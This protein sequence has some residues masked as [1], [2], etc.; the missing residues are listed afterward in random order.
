MGYMG[1]DPQGLSALRSR[2]NSALGDLRSLYDLCADPA[3]AEAK[4]SIA[5]A[6]QNLA[7]LWLPIVD[8]VL[9]C[10]PLSK[11]QPVAT[12][13]APGWKRSTD[14]LEPTSSPSTALSS[15][16]LASFYRTKSWGR[17]DY[18]SSRCPNNSPDPR[19][20]PC[21][22]P[23][24]QQIIQPGDWSFKNVLQYDTNLVLQTAKRCRLSD[25]C[26]FFSFTLVGTAGSARPQSGDTR[27]AAGTDVVSGALGFVPI[28]G[29]VLDSA[30]IVQ[31]LNGLVAGGSVAQPP[32][33]FD[34]DVQI[35]VRTYGLNGE[36]LSSK[37]VDTTATYYNLI[38][39]QQA[40]IETAMDHHDLPW[41][42]Y[43]PP[44][45]LTNVYPNL[46]DQNYGF[47]AQVTPAAG[48]GS[49][50]RNET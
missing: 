14:P 12:G 46:D 18:P 48:I 38:S 4:S 16:D 37:I 33:T 24:V 17:G 40:T 45:G 44:I 50:E 28:A 29:Q 5:G 20:D 36:V 34:V 2:L 13:S 30:Q 21:E 22:T 11:Y 35:V 1:Y 10:D 7:N 26:A 31:G 25:G 42:W 32:T 3:A 47:M 27:L 49:Q 23:R 6:V 15:A 41:Q 43:A 19:F 9:R 8:T 39:T